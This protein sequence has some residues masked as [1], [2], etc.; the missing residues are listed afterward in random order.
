MSMLPVNVQ[1]WIDTT[2]EYENFANAGSDHRAGLCRLHE[3]LFGPD[4]LW[5]G[6]MCYTLSWRDLLCSQ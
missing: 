2:G 5:S 6:P 3:G 4:C 1:M